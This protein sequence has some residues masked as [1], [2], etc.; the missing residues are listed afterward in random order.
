[1]NLMNDLL[2]S[3]I[4]IRVTMVASCTFL[5]YIGMSEGLK[6]RER[7]LVVRLSIFMAFLEPYWKE[8]LNY[9][10]GNK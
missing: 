6:K 2:F 3:L 10:C 9:G 8:I 1:M 5:L 4:P 7:R